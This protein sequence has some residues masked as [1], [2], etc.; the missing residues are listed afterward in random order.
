MLP[1]GKRTFRKRFKRR[2]EYSFAIRKYFKCRREFVFA[3]GN[4]LNVDRS[5]LS[6]SGHVLECPG[7][8]ENWGVSQFA[9]TSAAPEPNSCTMHL[10]FGRH[11]GVADSGGGV[12]SSL[13][14]TYEANTLRPAPPAHIALAWAGGRYDTNMG[15]RRPS[16]AAVR[17]YRIEVEIF[18]DFAT[19]APPGGGSFGSTTATIYF[20][21]VVI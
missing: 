17:N 18:L 9:H 2:P 8:P 4:I 12:L 6:P 16:T 5:I 7:W 10:K 1:D 11:V 3:R 21:W 20:I 14:D 13:F 19:S 15:D